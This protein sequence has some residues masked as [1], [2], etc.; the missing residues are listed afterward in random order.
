[1][2]KEEVLI[3]TAFLLFVQGYLLENVFPAM[4]GFSLAIYLVYLRNSFTPAIDVDWNVDN[5]LVEGEKTVTKVLLR[6]RSRTKL[7]IQLRGDFLPENFKSYPVDLVLNP[8][9]KKSVDFV[10]VP[11]RGRYRIKGPKLT[12]SDVRGLYKKQ[13]TFGFE[14]D[15]EVIPSLEGIKEEITADENIR[16][17]REYRKFLIGLQSMELHSLKRFQPGDDIKHIEWK[18][19]ARLGEIIVKD[20]LKET[21]EDVYLI[22]D[23]GKEMRKGV[24]KSKIDY[25]TTLTLYLSHIL[26]KKYRVGLVIFDDFRVI[27]KIEASKS[28]EH[29]QK[30]MKALAISPL[31]TE[32]LGLKVAEITARI[33]R[34]SREFIRRIF[35]ALKGRRG[36]S[37]GL[38]EVSGAIPSLATL[39]F[40]ADVTSHTSELVRIL[41][42]LKQRHRIFLLTPN[43]VL[44]Y[45]ISKLDKNTI[46]NLYRKY[47]EREELIRRFNRVVPTLDLGPSDLSEVIRGVSE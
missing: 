34:E 38:A 44:F 31:K 21:E 26:L 6:N 16:L 39:I 33:S 15:V 36:T 29:I 2:K 25:A 9:E 23:A 42:E 3:L 45:D 32:V 8:Q 35:P 24:K 7:R 37:S 11:S 20:F 5:V 41:S 14:F 22:L 47:I 46:L 12:I 4:L 27:Q 43:P 17:A 1:M 40:I 28:P 10:L 19:T 13:L 18:A 30:I